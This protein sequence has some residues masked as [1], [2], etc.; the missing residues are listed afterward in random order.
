MMPSSEVQTTLKAAMNYRDR[1]PTCKTC[2]YF[3][4]F[5]QSGSHNA[6]PAHC[7]ANKIKVTVSERGSCDHYQEKGT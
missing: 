6:L 4:D 3:V 5:D 7:T 1:A 2:R